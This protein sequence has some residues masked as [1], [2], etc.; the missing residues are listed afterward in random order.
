MA[1]EVG[2]WNVSNG[3]D[4]SVRGPARPQPGANK[5]KAVLNLN[6]ANAEEVLRVGKNVPKGF[7]DNPTVFTSPDPPLATSAAHTADLDAK[8]SAVTT[9]AQAHTA[10]VLARDASAAVV[11]AD[12]NVSLPYVQK[13]SGGDPVIIAKA[14][15]DTKVQPTPV[16]KLP[17]VQNLSLT[18]GDTP[19]TVDSHWNSVSG[20]H[21]YEHM[22]CTGDPTVEANWTMVAG[23]TGSKA[24]H[25]GL[26]SGTRLWSRVRAK[27]PKTVNNGPWSQPAT[28]IV[29]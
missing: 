12:L 22:H 3:N 5:M 26:T 15:L 21:G 14:N 17:Q 6:N 11:M 8:I 10:A 16:G 18:T 28:I 20:S 13:V 23:S 27:A 29:P 2:Q 1:P 19:G 7:S 4:G 9:A 25:T 24:S